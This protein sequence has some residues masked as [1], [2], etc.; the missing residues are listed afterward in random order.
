MISKKTYLAAALLAGSASMAQAAEHMVVL[1]GF[2]YF[3]A[4]T[5][6]APGDTVVFINESGEDQTVVG[7]DSGWVIGPLSDLGEGS[8]VVT[9]ETEL[10][11]FAA[12][13][14]EMEDESDDST[15][16]S[17][18]GGASQEHG[19]YDDAPIRA[20]ISFETPNLSES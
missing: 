2:S 13:S 16:A 18:D 10:K 6:A 4:V 3:P 12:Y 9:E 7:K 15:T 5:Y 17:A 8:L 19:T 1:T 11:F 20:E 14:D